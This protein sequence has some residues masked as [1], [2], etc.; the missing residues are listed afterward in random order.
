MNVFFS[1]PTEIDVGNY[2]SNYTQLHTSYFAS[3]YTQID[4]SLIIPGGVL[5]WAKA[6]SA[7]SNINACRLHQSV[8][9][10]IPAGNP[11]HQINPDPNFTFET[12]SGQN[13]FTS[14]FKSPSVYLNNYQD[15]RI[16][17]ITNE[18]LS[19]VYGDEKFNE[20]KQK[21]ETQYIPK[22]IIVSKKQNGKIAGYCYFNDDNIYAFEFDDKV[23]FSSSSSSNSSS[24]TMSQS[25]NSSNSSSQKQL[26]SESSASSQSSMSS[27]SSSSVSLS[28]STCSSFYNS[29]SSSTISASSY[30]SISSLSSMSTGSSSTL[31]SISSRSSYSSSSTS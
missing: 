2:F 1:P 30:S 3:N 31:S 14:Y 18:I 16:T 22:K 29:S 24:L 13:I 5:T 11:S 12:I 17:A 28:S 6:S 23:D 21:L 19:F 20:E 26:S 8:E 4:M 10:A 25:S 9:A 7:L 27:G 15:P